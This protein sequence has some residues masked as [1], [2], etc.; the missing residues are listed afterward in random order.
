MYG[1]NNTEKTEN[2]TVFVGKR[3]RTV[4]RTRQFFFKRGV[5]YKQLK[6]KIA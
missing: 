5:Y 6:V 2:T 4:P 3:K 1:V